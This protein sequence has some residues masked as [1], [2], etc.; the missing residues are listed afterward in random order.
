MFSRFK[1]PAISF[2]SESWLPRLPFLSPWWRS[3]SPSIKWTLKVSDSV[4]KIPRRL[5]SLCVLSFWLIILSWWLCF[6][7]WCK[8]FICME[9]R[10]KFK[11]FL[12]TVG[13]MYTNL[14]KNAKISVSGKYDYVKHPLTLAVDNRWRQTNS[15]DFFNTCIHTNAVRQGLGEF[16]STTFC[17][18]NI[19]FL[20][21]CGLASL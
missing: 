14:A 3:L 8:Q 19:S 21:R 9:K 16:W 15:V 20:F 12:H 6:S 7:R 10:P 11:T 5:V 1:D 13:G 17:R 4:N 2:I 18:R